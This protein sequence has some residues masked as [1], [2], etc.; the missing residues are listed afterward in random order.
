MEKKNNIRSRFAPSPSGIMHV[1][2][3]RSALVNFLC[4]KENSGVFVLRIEDTDQSRTSVTYLENIYSV[5]KIL[6]LHPDEGPCQ[7]GDY[8]PYIQSERHDVYQKY[9][10]ILR[11][12]GLVY[13]CFKTP[14]ELELEK[15]KQIAL[16]LP[17]RYKRYYYSEDQEA[18]LLQSGKSFVW[19]LQINKGKSIFF[20]K[21]KGMMSFDLE[22]FSDSPVTRQD[23]SFTFL[24][25]NFVD[26]VEMHITHVI[27]GEE[28]LSNTVV[29]S[30]LYDLFGVEKPMF[31]HLPLI[32]DQN[33]K[34]LSKRNFGF[35][36]FD[37]FEAGY[38]PQ[39]ILNYI[40]IIGM[41]LEK[42]ILSLDDMITQRL[43]SAMKSTG[44]ITYDA[45]KLEW[46]NKKWMQIIT[47]EEL[48]KIIY[49]LAN[50]G[51]SLYQ[52]YLPYLEK[53][54]DINFLNSLKNESHTMKDFFQYIMSICYQI[55]DSKIIFDANDKDII[56]YCKL[57]LLDN[58]EC[59]ISKKDLYDFATFHQLSIKKV[60]QIMRKI[61]I[62]QEDGIGVLFLIRY[63][64]KP[65]LLNNISLIDFVNNV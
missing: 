56:E 12:K 41:S 45:E 5:L 14:E 42:E 30:Y 28:H 31:Y 47:I 40:G 53:I 27:R 22:H 35:N 4:A 1:G 8:G 62:K 49:S 51:I 58:S 50:Q 33:G 65:T 63:V 37:L 16:K 61:L 26:D 36:V 55:D 15:E 60:F 57:F 13:R 6:G 3:V 20:D 9:L 59:V 38:L 46:I 54:S 34:K 7:G 64:N 10:S 19:R 21:C 39:A 2:N 43:F 25:A 52:Q 23:G 24:F 29:Q 11:D 44:L 17:P 32:V 48:K 18:A